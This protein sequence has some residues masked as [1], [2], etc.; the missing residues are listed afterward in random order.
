MKIAVLITVYNRKEKTLKC[1]DSLNNTYFLHPEIELTVYLTDDCCTDGTA[2][3][4]INRGYRFELHVL[5]SN[6]NLYWNGG[7][8]NS[9]Q[10]ALRAKGQYDGYLWLND[11]TRL[12]SV[13]WDDLLLAD[14]FSL[15]KY[16]RKGI[17]VGSTYDPDTGEFTYGGFCFVNKWT[18]KDRFL[19]PDGEH[20]QPCQCA[21]GNITY[22]SREV[23]DTCGIFYE[24]YI[25]GG[26][27]HDYT[28]LA[29]KSGFP[30]LV[31]PH[32]AGTCV[33]DHKDDGY[34]EFYKMP[35]KE[36]IK[37]LNSPFGFNLH[38]T[39]L[40]Q[41]RCFPYR[42]PFVRCMGYL[43]ALFPRFYMTMYKIARK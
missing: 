43:K 12:Q 26:A 11:D 31:L 35:L 16:G 33:N 30:L 25:H 18:L 23:V 13:F 10:A 20:F 28:Y 42:T 1:L 41:K 37:Y 27:D 7:M 34:E 40:F 21:H 22:V 29:Y 19:E 3:A 2:D 17:Y 24:G 36:R 5:K 4:V 32:Y 9:W 39:L 15:V 14:S 8:I 6:G 38:N